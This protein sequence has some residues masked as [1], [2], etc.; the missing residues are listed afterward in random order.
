[1]KITFNHVNPRKGDI[2]ERKFYCSFET[3]D[4][5][6]YIYKSNVVTTSPWRR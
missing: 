2:F 4:P 1:M 3:R 6:P 5:C